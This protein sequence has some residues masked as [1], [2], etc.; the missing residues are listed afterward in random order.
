[1]EGFIA[2]LDPEEAVIDAVKDK[3]DGEEIPF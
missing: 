3:F 2:I 1:M